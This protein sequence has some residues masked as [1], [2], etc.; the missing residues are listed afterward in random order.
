MSD[1]ES[2][3]SSASESEDERPPILSIRKKTPLSGLPSAANSKK[4]SIAAS[5]AAA[6]KGA[7]NADSDDDF[8]GASDDES[9]IETDDEDEEEFHSA[10]VDDVKSSLRKRAT[11]TSAVDDDDDESDID[12]F[13]KDN[14]EDDDGE[15]ETIP[16]ESVAAAARGRGRF[17]TIFEESDN[18]DDNVKN[19]NYLMK[20][21]EQMRNN[22]IS[23]YHPELIQHSY[24]EIQTL[25]TVVR[26]EDGVVCDPLHTT[27][28]F[29]TKYEKTRIIGERA[30]QIN[31]GS[32]P[33]VQIPDGMIDGY[34]IALLEYE[35]KK[36][37]FIIKRPL[38]SGAVEYWPVSELELL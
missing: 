22:I 30:Q 18:E 36:I 27:L 8:E 21:D 34:L 28:P 6:V 16:I 19:E 12:E 9:E 33:L 11:K 17:E 2:E 1:Y 7:T 23:D 32:R 29:I 5:A 3:N 4:S 20:F 15:Q 25:A 26:D 38:P 31:S 35:Q 24:E 14:L 10:A 37:P 13:D